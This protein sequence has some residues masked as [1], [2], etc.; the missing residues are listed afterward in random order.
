MYTK[1]WLSVKVTVREKLECLKNLLNA[2]SPPK[3]AFESTSVDGV[4]YFVFNDRYAL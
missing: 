1:Q 3:G 2:T 4:Q